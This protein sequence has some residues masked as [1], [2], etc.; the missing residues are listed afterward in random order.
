MRSKRE[1]GRVMKNLSLLIAGLGASLLLSLG[2]QR[3]AEWIGLA[4]LPYVSPA[5]A[6]SAAETCV[7]PTNWA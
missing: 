5:A 2:F 3:A 1:N 7:L 6:E 4:L